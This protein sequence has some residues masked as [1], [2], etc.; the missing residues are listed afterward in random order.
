MTT[1]EARSSQPSLTSDIGV[2]VAK[3]QRLVDHLSPFTAAG[4]AVL[5]VVRYV[6]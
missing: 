1:W 6:P 5:Y 3:Y 2:F 4:N